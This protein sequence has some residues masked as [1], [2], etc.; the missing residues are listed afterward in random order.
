V[1]YG[2]AISQAVSRRLPT[3]AAQVRLYALTCGICLGQRGAASGFLRVLQFP[4][5]SIPPIAPHPSSSIFT[6]WYN[7]ANSGR[8]TELA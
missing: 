1:K 4:L 5:P 8:R 7:R 6:D 3:K 2:R